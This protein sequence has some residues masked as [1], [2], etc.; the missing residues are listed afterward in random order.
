M[1]APGSWLG[2]LGG[3]QL[4]RMF[5]M[6]A[7]SM[8]YKV[9]VLDPG[10]Q[11]PAGSVADEHLRA[12]YLDREALKKMASRCAA[13]TTEFENVPAESLAFLA[14]DAVVSPAAAAVAVAQDR[15]REKAFLAEE[16]FAVA[17]FAIINGERDLNEARLAPLLPGILKIARLGYDGKGQVRVST[18]AEVRNAFADLGGRSCVLEKFLD[19]EREISVVV[20]R[21]FD[22]NVVSFPVSENQHAGGILDVGIV[23]ARISGELAQN[24]RSTAIQ[25]AHRLDYRGVLCVE[26]FVLRDGKLVVNE[27]APRP[28]NSGHYTI[29]ACITSQFEQQV[30][31]LCG[32]PL[33]DTAAHCPAVMVNLLGD[34]WAAGEP[35]W[36]HVWQHARAKLHLY[37]KTEAKPGRKMGHFTVLA[38]EIDS[39]LTTALEIKSNLMADVRLARAAGAA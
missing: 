25:I 33:G 34:L 4:G 23:P 3:G 30:R 15:I 14:Q 32:L 37:G 6:A 28:H 20:A 2:L 1:I 29:D 36:E 24:A 22:N 19:L 12:E 38:E 21:G 13:A 10:E 39:A 27:I 26:F 5:T 17:P 8:G 11:G 35:R 18:P 9:L 16:G 7:Q 31:V